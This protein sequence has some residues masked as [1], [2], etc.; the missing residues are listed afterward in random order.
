MIPC[1]TR[2]SSFIHVVVNIMISFFFQ[3]FGCL[4]TL[5]IVITAAM[6]LI[7]FSFPLGIYP[8]VGFLDHM[9]VLFL[10]FNNF[11]CEAL[12]NFSLWQIL[13][14]FLL[15]CPGLLLKLWPLLVKAGELLQFTGITQRFN[16]IEGWR[17]II[18]SH[19]FLLAPEKFFF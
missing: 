7:L 6:S 19:V 10:F 5:S 1:S 13:F 8:E 11:C 9:V 4:H 15:Y 17:E 16:N 18:F 14:I 12:R 3:H 2:S